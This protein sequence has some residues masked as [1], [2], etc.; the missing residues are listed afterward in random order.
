MEAFFFTLCALLVGF[1]CPIQAAAGATITLSGSDIPTSISLHH[2]AHTDSNGHYVAYES[3][4]TRTSTSETDTSS[5]RSFYTTTSESYTPIVGSQSTSTVTANETTLSGNVTATETSR[6]PLPTNTRPCNGYPEFCARSYGNITQVAAHN[7]P[8]V[9]PGNIASNQEL[10]VI[11]QLNDGIRMLQFQ[12]HYM[13]GTV[14]LCHS[15]CDLLNAGTLESY[16]KKVAEWLK[17]NPYDV[18]TILIGNG[19]F[20]KATNF[21]APIESSGLIDHVFTPKKPTLALDEWPTLSEI[22]L[23]GKRAVVFMD[24]EANQRDVPYI[25]DEFAHMWETPFSPTDRNFP[26]DVQRPPGLNEAD[27]RKRMYMANHNLNLEISIAGTTI[28]VPNSVLLN[29]TNAVS[30]FGSIGAMGGNCTEKWGRPPNFLLVDYYNVGN[31]NGSVFQVAAKLNNVTYNGKCCG[32]TTSLA[33]STVFSGLRTIYTL[34]IGWDVDQ[35]KNTPATPSTQLQATFFSTNMQLATCNI[36]GPWQAAERF[37]GRVSRYLQLYHGSNRQTFQAAVYTMPLPILSKLWPGAPVT[38]E[39]APSQSF[40]RRRPAI[41][42]RILHSLIYLPAF[43]MLLLVQIA[44]V[45]NKPV[46]RDIYFLKIDLSNIIPLTVPNAVLINS[47]ARTIGLHDFYQVGLWNFCEGYGDGSGITRCSKPKATYA[48][49]PVEIIT[50]ELLAG[51]TS[52]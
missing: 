47:I 50:S 51:A 28:L 19:D 41:P 24:Y 52:Q 32:R 29:E 25:L 49:N 23:S 18:L 6:E 42:H 7:S 11:T 27:A 44:N 16:L 9:R 45:S 21:T 20:I 39:K 37:P 46:L 15:S 22:I 33:S 31:V 26:C 43:V 30:G 13:N 8:F 12:T 38:S 34:R 40:L 35:G 3:S 14:Y 48:F 2:A 5:S 17:A 4:T 36:L 1:L 10:E